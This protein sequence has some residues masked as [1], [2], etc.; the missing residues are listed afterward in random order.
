[1]QRSFAHRHLP[2]VMAVV[3]WLAIYFTVF[4]SLKIG[5]AQE[6]MFSTPDSQEYL[7]TG[8]EFLQLEQAGFSH[9][10]RSSFPY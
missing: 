7:V 4:F 5:V 9:T 6:I 3:V 2:L 10:D 1:M 8:A